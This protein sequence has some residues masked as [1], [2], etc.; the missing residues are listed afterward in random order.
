M[1]FV[2]TY[3]CVLLMSNCECTAAE[4]DV[5]PYQKL[6]TMFQ[7]VPQP[8]LWYFQ[9]VAEAWYKVRCSN[10]GLLAGRLQDLSARSFFYLKCNLYDISV[11]GDHSL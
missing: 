2:Y 6:G 9:S 8:T 3:I 1:L 5:A 10:P 11:L 7:W 4:Y